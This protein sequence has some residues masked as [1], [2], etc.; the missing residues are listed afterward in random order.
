[1][2][3]LTVPRKPKSPALPHETITTIAS[4]LPFKDRRALLLS[5]WWMHNTVAPV[6]YRSLELCFQPSNWPHVGAHDHM[7]FAILACLVESSRRAI[8]SGGISSYASCIVT[9][10]FVSHRPGA[11]LRAIPMLAQVLRSATH[12]RHLRIDVLSDAIPL[13]LDVFGRTN[14]IQS[15][16]PS[17]VAKYA[18]TTTDFLPLPALDTIRSSKPALLEALMRFRS[19][20]TAILDSYPDASTFNRLFATF[21]PLPHHDLTRLSIVLSPNRDHFPYEL[22]AIV[23]AFPVLEHLSVRCANRVATELL[24]VSAVVAFIHTYTMYTLTIRAARSWDVRRR[25]PLPPQTARHRSQSRRAW[26]I[27]P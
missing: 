25:G 5:S 8:S 17:L 18:G 22:T 15:A 7:P 27:L 16:T 3:A 12:L 26:F 19:V 24:V 1:M 9:L 2:A 4:I 13:I 23:H 14:V 20:K 6:L 21:S 10:S 11:N